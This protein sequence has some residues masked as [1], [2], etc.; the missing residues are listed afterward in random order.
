[1][2]HAFINPKDIPFMFLFTVSLVTGFS[3]VDSMKA[4]KSSLSLKGSVET[5]SKKLRETDAQAQRKFLMIVAITLAIA[6]ALFLFSR[7]L[8]FLIEQIVTFFYA[9]KSNSWAGR[10]FDTVASHASGISKEDYATKA[11]RLFRRVKRIIL[12]GSSTVFPGIFWPFDQSYDVASLSA[13]SMEEARGAY[14]KSD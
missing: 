2:G 5:L 3:L 10:I 6:L 13:Q 12:A 14:H 11:V 4:E 7:Q 8:N 1:M 9:A